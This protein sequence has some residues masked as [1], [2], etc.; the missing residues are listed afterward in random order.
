MMSRRL[1]VSQAS[2][3]KWIKNGFNIE[4]RASGLHALRG[5][6]KLQQMWYNMK[7]RCNSIWASKYEYYGGKGIRVEMSKE[8][9][10]KIWDRDSGATQKIPSID[11]ID[12]DGNYT[13][14]NCRIVEMRFNNHR[15]W[16]NTFCRSCLKKIENREIT[17]RSMDVQN[18]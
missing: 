9:L 17:K 5:N 8:D 1:D 12:S 3:S 18:G 11:R 15:R 14:E 13:Y 2:I 7:H 16:R 10:R 6:K 4:S